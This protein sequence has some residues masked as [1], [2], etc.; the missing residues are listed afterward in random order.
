M[1]IFEWKA[2][3][4]T[5][6]SRPTLPQNKK[7]KKNTIPF[8]VFFFNFG[9]RDLFFTTIKETLDLLFLCRKTLL[10]PPPYFL[11]RVVNAWESNVQLV[12][13]SITSPFLLSLF[14]PARWCPRTICTIYLKKSWKA[15]GKV[16]GRKGEGACHLRATVYRQTSRPKEN[17]PKRL[18]HE[19]QVSIVLTLFFFDD[20][21]QKHQM[22][23]CWC[24]CS[25]VSCTNNYLDGDLWTSHSSSLLESKTTR[26]SSLKGKKRNNENIQQKENERAEEEWFLNVVSRHCHL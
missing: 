16:G 21:S 18:D 5:S 2:K 11:T 22:G 9:V 23:T 25:L 1:R 20:L 8:T 13:S 7:T 17:Q 24:R 4:S 15:R 26:S 12:Y 3:R 6:P 10:V 19:H 14:L